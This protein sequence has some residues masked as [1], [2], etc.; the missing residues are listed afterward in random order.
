MTLAWPILSTLIFG[1]G[2]PCLILCC[3]NNVKSIR[4]SHVPN[5][6]NLIFGSVFDLLIVAT[7]GFSLSFFIR[8]ESVGG[9]NDDFRG[10]NDDEHDGQRKFA[11]TY[12]FHDIFHLFSS[13]FHFSFSYLE[14]FGTDN[15]RH[16]CLCCCRCNLY[17]KPY[18]LFLFITINKNVNAENNKRQTLAIIVMIIVHSCDRPP[19]PLS[20]SFSTS[21]VD[22]KDSMA[23]DNVT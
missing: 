5:S 3:N 9:F 19:P 22:G 18:D 12:L 2:L 13:F 10:F 6:L 17:C 1:I 7:N 15:D 23:T 8:N 16:F 20:P 21:F 11:G 4:L 14:K